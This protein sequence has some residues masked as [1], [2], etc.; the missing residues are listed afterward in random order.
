MNKQVRKEIRKHLG[1]L[2]RGRLSDLPVMGMLELQ[3][4]AF[5]KT[6]WKGKRRWHLLGRYWVTPYW[7][8][9][10]SEYNIHDPVEVMKEIRKDYV[11]GVCGLPPSTIHN[12]TTGEIIATPKC[13]CYNVLREEIKD[14]K[15]NNFV[16]ENREPCEEQMDE[17]I[18]EVMS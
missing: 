1:D 5:V 6:Y 14:R 17:S 9:I 12:S 13:N 2:L 18:S 11:C 15:V 4:K 3:R 16:E 8:T 10:D 7:E